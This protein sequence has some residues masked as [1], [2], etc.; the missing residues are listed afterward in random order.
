MGVDEIVLERQII[1]RCYRIYFSDFPLVANFFF[2]DQDFIALG[3][4]SG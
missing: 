4:A 3:K 2:V 1:T